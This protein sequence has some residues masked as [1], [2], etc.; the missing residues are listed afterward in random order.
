M[1]SYAKR[2]IAVLV[3]VIAIVLPVFSYAP[4]L[5]LWFVRDQMNKLYRRLRIV[6]KALLT[7]LTAADVQGLQTDLDNIDRS[8]R[9]IVSMRPS[10]FLT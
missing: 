1:T 8:A 6:D 4:K 3:T 10:C 9:I 7:E 5:Y 2:I